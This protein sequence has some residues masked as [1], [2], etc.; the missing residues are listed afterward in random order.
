MF[1][2]LGEPIGSQRP[3][4]TRASFRRP[5]K[6]PGHLIA[7]I[8]A[9]LI[10]ISMYSARV[11]DV[12]AS[13]LSAQATPSPLDIATFRTSRRPGGQSQQACSGK[14]SLDALYLCLLI[15]FRCDI[16]LRVRRSVLLLMKTS[17]PLLA[18]PKVPPP[19][20]L[21]TE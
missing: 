17:P 16:V 13:G 15:L 3:V 8:M 18:E 14:L 7:I 2:S 19:P 11:Y 10:A 9:I 20:P 1:D 4:T 5:S 12:C 21:S 6:P